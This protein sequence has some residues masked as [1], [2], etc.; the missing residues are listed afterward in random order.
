MNEF[1]FKNLDSNAEII[2][3]LSANII[4]IYGGNGTG[5]TTFSRQ[6]SSKIENSRV[7]NVDFINKN[8]YIVDTDGAKMDPTTKEN[9]SKLFISEQAVK[10]ASE[11]MKVKEINK[12]IEPLK[13]SSNNRLNQILKS[14][15]LDSN[16]DLEKLTLKLSTSKLEFNFN[17]SIENNK[18]GIEFSNV[19]ETGINSDQ[20]MITKI[21]QY[22]ANDIMKKI[23][24]IIN[25]TTSLKEI[26]VEDNFIVNLNGLLLEFNTAVEYIKIIEKDFNK[27]KNSQLFKKWIEDGLKIH[28]D[29]TTCLFCGTQNIEPS[30][31]RWKELIEN[32]KVDIKK[33]ILSKIKKAKEDF[34]IIISNKGVYESII[35]LIISTIEKLQG[36][37]LDLENEINQNLK[38]K[39]IDVVIEKDLVESKI[40]AAY[41][42]IITYLLNQDLMGYFF[43]FYYSIYLQNEQN[44]LEKQANSESD[45]FSKSTNEAIDNVAK[46][47]G[48]EKD[49]KIFLETR[50]GSIPR[51]SIGPADK[52]IKIG[53]FSEGQIH[54]LA[55]AIFFADIL[56][57]DKTYDFIV[58]DDPII[59]LD[60]V[61]YHKLKSFIIYELKDKYKK[62]IILTHNI[63]FL[64]I[65]LSNLIRE[66]D[67]LTESE[68]LELKPTE[69]VKIPIQTIAKDDIILFKNAIDNSTDMNDVSLWYWMIEKIARHFMDIK[70]SILGIVSFSD[71]NEDLS[72]IFI[73]DNLTRVQVIHKQIIET[74]KSTTSSICDIKIALENLNLFC[75]ELGFPNVISDSSLSVFK[76]GFS[77]DLLVVK[78]PIAKSLE[79]SIIKEGHKIVF[80][81]SK[82]NSFL[83]DYIMHPRHQITES[84]VAFEAQIDN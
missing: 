74:S 14:H 5:K 10:F 34:N 31:E 25:T 81:N 83:K 11:M 82:E 56:I 58:L 62:S 71:V 1:A 37:I 47:L 67:K 72:K 12:T 39:L 2:I 32:K 15:Q 30:L 44:R 3:P 8:V 57:K 41:Y 17:E 38:V 26:F 75:T 66:S 77:G 7:F 59:S 76:D 68:L 63:G 43:P 19:L 53:T 51:M 28:E 73:G 60:V 79:F 45:K 48:L 55:L 52:S 18:T 70:L 27:S 29:Q 40:E 4:Y 78:D 42:E 33:N 65:M 61:A 16:F 50:K 35:P 84:L 20:E 46:K 36:K 64:L 13:S 49:L 6:F 69:Y 9:F 24:E 23:H 22:K 80:N 54:K 21:K